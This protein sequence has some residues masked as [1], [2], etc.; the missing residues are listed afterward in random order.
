VELI[1]AALA[2]AAFAGLSPEERLLYAAPPPMWP[3]KPD[4][5]K[6][7]PGTDEEARIR[8]LAKAGALIAAEIDR[9]Q[10]AKARRAAVED[11]MLVGRWAMQRATETDDK[12]LRAVP[13]SLL[14]E[15]GWGGALCIW[16][17]VGGVEFVLSGSSVRE[18]LLKPEHQSG[19]WLIDGGWGAPPGP[20]FVRWENDAW[21][22][23]GYWTD[24]GAPL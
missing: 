11:A 24:R 14:N 21:T 6:P 19:T 15:R 8:E 4:W 10:R 13:R 9:L 23:G 20:L 2:Y 12:V 1:R 18:F 5:W 7:S 3:W 22:Y 16:R 17:P